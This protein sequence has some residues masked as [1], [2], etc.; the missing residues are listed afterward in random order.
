MLVGTVVITSAMLRGRIGAS[1]ERDGPWAAAVTFRAAMRHRSFRAALSSNVVNGWTVYGI[2]VAIVPL[3]VVEALGRADGW[4]GVVLAGFAAGTAATLFLGGR[5]ADR[6]GR[7]PPILVGSAI[8]GVT[9]LG[10][11]SCSTIPELVTIAVLSGIGTGLMSPPV[12]AA[13]GD[14][15]GAHGREADGGTALAGFQMFGDVG[16]I[17]GPVLAGMIVEIGGY[18]AAFATTAAIAA[19]SFGYWL[20]APETLPS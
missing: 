9:S 3:F 8:V 11:G 1:R 7:R 4:S 5:L 16:A 15:I 19:V 18:P 2:R 12:N 17:V 6:R 13:V 14:V 20:R 10:M